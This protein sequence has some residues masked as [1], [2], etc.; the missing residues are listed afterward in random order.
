MITVIAMIIMVFP[1]PARMVLV[2]RVLVLTFT[3][4]VLMVIVK[5]IILIVVVTC[6]ILLRSNRPMLLGCLVISCT[7]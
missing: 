2:V 3:I 6:F 7:G 5:G 4:M 1:L